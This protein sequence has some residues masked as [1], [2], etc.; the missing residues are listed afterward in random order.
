MGNLDDVRKTTQFAYVLIE[1]QM[2]R[3]LKVKK[4]PHG[5]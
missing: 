2:S 1:K 3:G 4:I 5:D